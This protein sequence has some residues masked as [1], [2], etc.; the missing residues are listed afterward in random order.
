MAIERLE[1][2]DVLWCASNLPEPL[3]VALQ[4][5]KGGAYVAGGHVRSCIAG[6]GRVDVDVFATSADSEE[7]LAQELNL[8]VDE[9]PFRTEF[10]RTYSGAHAPIQ[11]ISRWHFEG[12]EDLIHHFDFTVS[13]ALIFWDSAAKRW[14]GF[15]GPRFY[16]DLAARRLVFSAPEDRD[17]LQSGG[18]L[19]RLARYSRKGYKATPETVARVAFEAVGASDSMEE[20]VRSL[21]GI[22]PGYW[23]AWVRDQVPGGEE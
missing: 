5:M 20:L 2:D 13:E 21:Q 11:L 15:C 12:A 8:F 1:P 6:E 9:D 18:T 10:A 17:R 3:A 7:E 16:R 19:L 22:D 4:G 14:E 23:P